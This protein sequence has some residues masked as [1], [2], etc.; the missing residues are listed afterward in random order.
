MEFVIRNCFV[1]LWQYLKNVINMEALVANR[2]MNSAQMFILQTFAAARS[3]RDKEELT[4]LYL[5]HIQKKMDEESDKWWK[6]NKMTQ[7]KLEEIL[8][9][10]H[11]TPHK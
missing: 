4:S 7:E 10:H 1:S 9:T 8:N 5:D 3:D 11:R 2:S 6:E